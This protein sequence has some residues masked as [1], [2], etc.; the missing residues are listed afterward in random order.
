MENKKTII[1][2]DLDYENDLLKN[3]NWSRNSKLWLG[4]LFLSLAVCLYFY[5][6]QLRDGLGVTGL[7]DYASWGIYIS[8]F[9]FFVAVS[10]VGM[11]ISSVLGLTKN[12]WVIPIGRISEIIALAFAMV[13]GLVIISDMGRPD[14]LYHIFFFGRVQS[15]IVWDVAVVTTYVFLSLL[16]LYI[17]LIPDFS[18]CEK[19]LTTLPKLQLKLYRIL[20]LGWANKPEQFELI[21]KTIRISLVTIIPVALAIHTVTSW[22]FALTLRPGWNSSIFG[23]YFVSGAFVAGCTA[24][25]MTMYVLRKRYNLSNY[26]TNDHFDRMGKLLVLVALVYIYFN[27]NEVLVPGYKS[28]SAEA[29]H[30]N[31]MLTGHEAVL[32]WIVQIGGLILPFFLLLI[33]KMRE[34][35][36]LTFL[37]TAIL[38]GAWFKRFLIVIPSQLEPYLP[39]Q[40]VPEKFQ[41]YVPTVPEIAITL[42]SF[43]LVLIII[44]ILS[45]TVPIV[46][47]WEM[48]EHLTE[49]KN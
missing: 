28:G 6:T 42:A 32:Y 25:I 9:V 20:S 39:I 10:L 4:F 26:I 14:R 19:K 3:V 11:L 41:L 36:P 43:I 33:K 18:L 44:T 24:L 1:A 29:K 45:K 22:L 47:V 30:I 15:P 2:S 27:L 40:N 13:A 34:P 46:P 31:E 23:P 49:N 48:K 8:N 17:P 7:H 35:L 16:L 12:E 5:F 38:I 21:K 37:A